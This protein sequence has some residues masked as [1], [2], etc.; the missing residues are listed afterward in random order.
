[1][2]EKRATVWAVLILALLMIAGCDAAAPTAAEA[3]AE[4]PS[5]T[6]VPEVMSIGLV[7]DPSVT[8]T[9]PP[10]P[11][12]TPTP[13]IT[14][15]P[16]S[17]YA[18]TVNM[19]FGELVGSTTDFGEIGSKKVIWPKGYPAA[20]TYQ[21]IVDIEWQV[22]LVYT[23]DE[24]GE[25]TVPVRY[26]LC[27]TG[28]PR[29]PSGSETRRGTFQI[30]KPRVRFGHFLSG[31][32]AQYWTLIRGRTYFHSILYDEAEKI[33]TY[34][35][36]SYNALGS[37]ASHACIRLTVPDARWIWYNIAYG[38]NCII[39][40]GSKNDTETA[41]IKSQ[42]VLPPAPSTQMKSLKAGQTPY[43]DTW[44]IEDVATDVPFINEKQPIPKME[45]D[46]EDE[47]D[48]TEGGT[49]T[50][51][52]G[53][54][55]PGT[56]GGT[57]DGTTGEGAGVTEPATGEGTEPEAGGETGGSTEPQTGG[58]DGGGILAPATDG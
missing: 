50:P 52:E 56:G 28:N 29:I 43:T 31:E 40:D 5:S 58:S 11:S 26:M 27:S 1:M 45:A 7:T 39:R 32:A 54:T 13:D 30:L 10:T 57:G 33:N 44:R 34:Q 35:T 46:D 38:T 15:V 3:T 51:A 37:K 48:P 47:D 53:T 49:S 42:L 25:Y 22:V 4:P 17:V 9:P 14:P 8:P 18:P 12:P 21:I 16:F 2:F 19:S 6:P 36:E 55:D 41:W 24:N 20:D 23:K